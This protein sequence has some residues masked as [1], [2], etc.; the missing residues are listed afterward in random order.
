MA[1]ADAKMTVE[2]GASLNQKEF[3]AVQKQFDTYLFNLKNAINIEVNP[4]I[5]KDLM[6]QYKVVEKIS[7]AYDQAFDSKTGQINITKLN[8]E[9]KNTNVTAQQFRQTMLGMKQ[10]GASLYNN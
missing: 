2:I 8:Q 5:K 9:M 4:K 7:L 3:S 10:D 6:E 1:N